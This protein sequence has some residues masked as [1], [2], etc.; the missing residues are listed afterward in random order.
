FVDG[1]WRGVDIDHPVD[2]GSDNDGGLLVMTSRGLVRFDGGVATAIGGSIV[3]TAREPVQVPSGNRYVRE[4][5]GRSFVLSGQSWVETPP[6]FFS[7]PVRRNGT[8]FAMVAGGVQKLE[9]ERTIAVPCEWLER[10][11]CTEMVLG[12]TDE[13]RIFV[14]ADND[15]YA[16]GSDV[17]K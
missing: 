11:T 6:M 14:G 4:E 3:A 12:G 15:I 10:A 1:R 17:V 2:F 7:R 16:V 9:A 5:P 13:E 8:L